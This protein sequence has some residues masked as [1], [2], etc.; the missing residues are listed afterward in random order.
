M[1]ACTG[2]FIGSS[3]R[4]VLSGFN[5]GCRKLNWGALAAGLVNTKGPSYI[6][7]R[8]KSTVDISQNIN[9][10]AS[11]STKQWQNN[12]LFPAGA[13]RL[14]LNNFSAVTVGE[15]Y[16]SD[17]HDL[18]KN[19]PVYHELS[20]YTS[21]I[22][23]SCPRHSVSALQLQLHTAIQ[24]AVTNPKADGFGLHDG[25]GLLG[26][27]VNLVPRSHREA[28]LSSHHRSI[29]IIFEAV[30]TLE[31]KSM[32][33]R[34]DLLARLLTEPATIYRGNI[35][36]RVATDFSTLTVLLRR[37]K[38]IMTQAELERF[39][40]AKDRFGRTILHV[41][42]NHC[43]MFHETVF[44][45]D[46]A[47]SQPQSQ[48][49]AQSQP[50][51][52]R[53]INTLRSLG[54]ADAT[55]KMNMVAISS[56]EVGGA[57][58]L[59]LLLAQ[60]RQDTNLDITSARKRKHAPTTHDPALRQTDKVLL[61]DCFSEW[62]D[63]L[64]HVE[65][66]SFIQQELPVTSAVFVGGHERTQLVDN[67]RRHSRRPD[68]RMRLSLTAFDL[69]LQS[70]SAQVVQSL[71]QVLC[72]PEVNNQ[73]VWE[74]LCHRKNQPQSIHWAACMEED[75]FEEYVK[76]LSASALPN[77][78]LQ[79]LLTATGGRP[80]L[81]RQSLVQHSLT[82]RT[83]P[84]HINIHQNCLH[85]AAQHH[86]G[87]FELLLRMFVTG[88]STSTTSKG[89]GLGL[90][91][92]I[93]EGNIGGSVLSREATL[94]MISSDTDPASKSILQ[95]V[96]ERGDLRM[97]KAWRNAI[98]ELNP[99]QLQVKELLMGRVD[100]EVLHSS[101][102]GGSTECV[103][104]YLDWIGDVFD[105]SHT[106][107][108]VV[109][110]SVREVPLVDYWV[111]V[112]PGVSALVMATTLPGDI[113]KPFLSYIRR[114]RKH[115]GL[116]EMF[117]EQFV[118][119]DDCGL[120]DA[121]TLLLINA[122]RTTTDLQLMCEEIFDACCDI[123]RDEEQA[124]SLVLEMLTRGN[125]L[126]KTPFQMML[127]HGNEE[128]YGAL[129][130]EIMRYGGISS[131][132]TSLVDSRVF[133]P[134][135]TTKL[136]AEL[137]QESCDEHGVSAACFHPF[138]KNVS[139]HPMQLAT[140]GNYDTLERYLR[141]LIH[142]VLTLD[143]NDTH[144]VA[145][146][147]HFRE[148]LTHAITDSVFSEVLRRSDVDLFKLFVNTMNTIDKSSNENSNDDFPNSNTFSLRNRSSI[149]RDVHI[150][151]ERADA[152]MLEAY[153][154]WISPT[155][156][157][158]IYMRGYANVR[159]STPLLT[160]LLLSDNPDPDAMS[161]CLDCLKHTFALTSSDE[162]FDLLMSPP[163]LGRLTPLRDALS[164]LRQNQH[165]A[166]KYGENFVALAERFNELSP[167][168]LQTI[169]VAQRCNGDTLFGMLAKSEMPYE[170]FAKVVMHLR[171]AA[172][173][174]L[175]KALLEPN[176]RGKLPKA[177]GRHSNITN[178]SLTNRLLDSLRNET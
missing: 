177:I 56:D 119:T 38:N 81:P 23:Q 105:S 129:K 161:R 44:H 94:E 107:R 108:L 57:S 74:L 97:V 138:T 41:L 169:F 62:F 145:M 17:R 172:P 33:D 112:P 8:S 115:T 131:F 162:L 60:L 53:L 47:Q 15:R 1:M 174:I 71:R 65:A 163:W 34:N 124:R 7:V 40:F 21:S 121:L 166:Q 114:M 95:L 130:T 99:S 70:N 137:L 37:A 24:E 158:D 3:T 106:A 117:L 155:T 35:L 16:I 116:H 75:V 148:T 125:L 73:T 96:F 150:I 109:S 165:Q 28:D 67:I 50:L 153:I 157:R 135:N 2:S 92:S 110:T 171:D 159:G 136:C 123:T 149:V 27:A 69:A 63:M 51:I 146:L 128:M 11:T 20:Q 139:K 178:I 36:T 120:W 45:S 86:A 64:T 156:F 168:F 104:Y 152:N 54:I 14:Y 143:T 134:G 144:F 59:H 151:L 29:Q 39:V 55:L 49:Q 142:V 83:S 79:R 46:Q 122:N 43:R 85:V 31:T 4:I 58:P 167:S 164:R 170:N 141:D 90:M 140:T 89:L 25:V 19:M 88:S 102:L 111:I 61:A 22:D 72:D 12:D 10:C 6:S 118:G 126:G 98:E 18:L 101:L 13:R 113:L 30:S 66:V 26:T 9:K 76:V 91:G 52:I 32:S 87:T 132:Q 175:A 100:G 127:E 78:H 5:Y 82:D 80:F 103:E 68:M 160:S 154:D 147:G 176:S 48:L 84:A 77:E 173:E 93:L 42:A 133:R